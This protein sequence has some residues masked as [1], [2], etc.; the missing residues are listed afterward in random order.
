M[1]PPL[2]GN[3]IPILWASAGLLLAGLAGTGLARAEDSGATTDTF[4][5]E[6]ISTV[7][8]L[9]GSGAAAATTATPLDPYVQEKNAARALGEGLFVNL[10]VWGYDRFLRAEEDRYQFKVGWQSWGEN[11][12]N[13]F[14]WDDNDFVTNQ[15]AHPYHGS[16]YYNAARSNGYSYW[17]SIP[18]TFAGSFMWEYF[19]ETHHPSM[20]DWVMTSVGGIALGETLYRLSGMLLDNT[21]TGSGRTWR[22]IGGFA[23]SP[24][25]GFNRLITGRS[26]RVYANP[27]DRLPSF[28]GSRLTVGG[29]TLGQER[30]WD[31]DTT[32][33]YLDFD[34]EYGDPFHGDTDKP[35][36]NFNFG[37]Q[38]N[39]N[40]QSGIGLGRARGWLAGTEVH[41]S[42]ASQHLLAAFHHYDYIN[43]SAYEFGAQSIGAALLSRFEA[44]SGLELRTE[45]HLKVLILGASKSDYPN[46]TGR[47]YDYG[48]G[49]GAVFR[50]VLGRGPQRLLEVS[51]EAYG[52]TAI[53]GN[54]A[55]HVLNFTRVRANLPLT[56][57]D[58]LGIEYQLYLADRYY[59]DYPDVSR[60]APE[61]RI[62]YTRMLSFWQ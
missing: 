23:I 22:E 43:N 30:L 27:P 54:T 41:A 5:S 8:L 2:R 61:L 19:G 7:A 4:V 42:D 9:T 1:T 50:V 21:A 15:F 51:H 56:A 11:L 53:N 3:R 20:N 32:R 58:G 40:D 12:K 33:V 39:F 18:F 10:F 29:R 16:L 34:F 24:M 49:L 25:R 37:L 35:Y 13:G 6:P 17:E 57:N 45:V 31:A 62:A 44:P 55:Q 48:P 46:F 36:A 38:I 59:D 52:L 26:S 47:D 60:R 14:E 28:Y